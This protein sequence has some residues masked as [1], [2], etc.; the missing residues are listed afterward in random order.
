MNRREFL[1]RSVIS[2]AALGLGSTRLVKAATHL[3]SAYTPNIVT[4]VI[5]GEHGVTLTYD[6]NYPHT[7]TLDSARKDLALFRI[8]IIGD[9][10]SSYDQN[11]P[12]SW[13]EFIFAALRPSC[14]GMQ[15][16]N[17]A[18]GQTACGGPNDFLHFGKQ[19]ILRQLGR[20][21]HTI[22]MLGTNNALLY[23]QPANEFLG[24]WINTAV[25]VND[26]CPANYLTATSLPPMVYYDYFPPD[27]VNPTKVALIPQ[28][29]RA[30]GRAVANGRFR[31]GMRKQRTTAKFVQLPAG[32][33]TDMW[34]D[35]V[36]F[37]D[38]ADSM[39]GSA[40][41]PTVLNSYRVT[42]AKAR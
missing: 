39:I 28:Y 9:S 27:W 5:S 41:T 7:D 20:A 19:E 3:E 36:H 23:T 26:L 12:N 38:T 15:L 40:L 22:V 31:A 4:K 1:L 6:A 35:G 14:P 8:L 37:G 30:L 25:A 29:N 32:V 42:A 2:T 34:N 33:A 13:P 18:Q 21:D 16:V 17:A 11:G 24:S 10:N